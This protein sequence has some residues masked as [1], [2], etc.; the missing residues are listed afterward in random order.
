MTEKDSTVLLTSSLIDNCLY[1]F[2][3]IQVMV[4]LILLMLLILLILPITRYSVVL[5]IYHRAVVDYCKIS[6]SNDTVLMH[7]RTHLSLHCAHAV[8][9]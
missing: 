4:L 3:T 9:W 8:G 1:K 2:H 7:T 5:L 6:I